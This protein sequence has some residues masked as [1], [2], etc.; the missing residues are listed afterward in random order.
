MHVK[1]Y[2]HN[3]EVICILTFIDCEINAL[4]LYSFRL[5]YTESM[6]LNTL[7]ICTLRSR[8]RT[9]E[10]CLVSVYCAYSVNINNV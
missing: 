9:R 4:K 10:Q 3:F 7:N 5:P 1:I 8:S 2:I 6:S